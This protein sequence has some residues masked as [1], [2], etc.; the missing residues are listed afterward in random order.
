MGG[1]F[2]LN[3]GHIIIHFIMNHE[4]IIFTSYIQEK[5]LEND[6]P[7]SPIRGSLNKSFVEY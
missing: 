3:D 6:T 7:T 1:C 4:I 5:L 2:A